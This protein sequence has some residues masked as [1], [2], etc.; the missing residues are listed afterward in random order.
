M[1]SIKADFINENFNTLDRKLT[2]I[3]LQNHQLE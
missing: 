3:L 1:D 2:N